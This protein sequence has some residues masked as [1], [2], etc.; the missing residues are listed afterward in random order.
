MIV[1]VYLDQNNLNPWFIFK[2]FRFKYDKSTSVIQMR[3][4]VSD[5][6]VKIKEY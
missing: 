2:F 1:R 3:T 6:V 5:K 4:L